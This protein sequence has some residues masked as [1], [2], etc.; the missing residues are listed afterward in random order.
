MSDADAVRQAWDTFGGGYDQAFGSSFT[1][2]ARAALGLAEVQAGMRLL[3]VAAGSGALS[4]PA[5]ELGAQVLATDLSPG[6]LELLRGRVE[7]AG[8][9]G[10]RT[11]V[12][13]GTDLDLAD[14]SFERVCSQFGVMLFPDPD[15]GL[16]EMFRLT[17][18]GGLGVVVIFGRAERVTPIWLV[19]Q[20]LTSALGE[21]EHPPG[22]RLQSDPLSL[23]GAMAT[24]GFVEVRLHLLDLGVEVG[25]PRGAWEV[26]SSGMGDLASLLSQLSSEQ[27][28]AVRDAFLDEVHARHGPD[29]TA[30][31]VEVVVGIGCR[32]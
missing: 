13:D 29:V 15:A 14:Q 12:M 27:A 11:S 22:N 16:R 3:D 2:I 25:S 8:V 17:A 5:A 30:L 7:A 10:I 31:P 28:H 18:T 19:R 32:R 4:I 23:A 1:A 24:A 6:M 20:A 21:L 26:V 9:T